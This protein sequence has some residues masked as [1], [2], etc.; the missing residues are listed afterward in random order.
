MRYLLDTT[1]LIDQAVGDAS[2]IELL[3]RLFEDGHEL[4]TCD[5]VS[6]EALSRGDPD[7]LRHIATLLDA[8][9]YV[10][11]SPTAARRAG[12][13]RRERNAAGGKRALRD[14]LIAG[15]AAE[16][17]AVIVTRNRRDFE[18]EGIKVLGY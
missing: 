11:T 3:R 9:E 14:A 15:V 6:C 8:L 13:A 7:A 1:L 2:A 4:Y 5:V 16:L 12:A 10:S 18:R 17:G